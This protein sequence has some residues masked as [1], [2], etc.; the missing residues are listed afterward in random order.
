MRENLKT[1]KGQY[2]YG[3]RM[4]DPVIGRFNTIDPLAEKTHDIGSYTY[5]LNN[6]IKMV[7]NDGRYAV[8]VHYNITYKAL[9]ALGYSKKDAD[10][11]AHY[12]STYADHPS[13]K[14]LYMDWWVHTTNTSFNGYRA[15]IDYSK[16]AESQDEKNS[17]W[18]A[19]MSDAEADAGMTEE[20]ATSRGLKFGWDN[21][22]ASN[23]GKDLGKLGQ[24]IHALQDATAHMGV[25]TNDHL[26]FNLS[27]AGKMLNDL[28]GS[29]KT[30]SNL[31]RSAGIITRLMAGKKVEFKKD[32][33]LNLQG[34]S[35][36]QFNQSIKLLMG[37][38]FQGTIKMN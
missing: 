15:G 31:T 18:H 33:E 25:K 10:V 30:A 2:D 3:A 29:T 6:P 24:G 16:T 23:G 8:S 4:Y 38:G 1:C 17:M 32:E 14:V 36:D 21:V 22:F 35:K 19:M 11:M 26:G 5:V 7:D 28:W 13:F 12:S 9:L 27:S 34:M 20:Q 37:A